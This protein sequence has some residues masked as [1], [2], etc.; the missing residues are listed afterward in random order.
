[1]PNYKVGEWVAPITNEHDQNYW[2]HLTQLVEYQN[3]FFPIGSKFGS[4][5]NIFECWKP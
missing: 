1:M 3:T 5:V 4:R 2:P